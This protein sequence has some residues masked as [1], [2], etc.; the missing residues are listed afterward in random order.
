MTSQLS[1]PDVI[2]SWIRLRKQHPVQALNA[3][4]QLWAAS[5]FTAPLNAPMTPT[6]VLASTQDAL[7]NV[8]CSRTIARQWQWPLVEHPSA[9]HDLP[10]DGARWVIDQVLNWECLLA[11]NQ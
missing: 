7:V 8:E 1:P 5:R 9:G 11:S 6:L 10:L 4:R 2:E 3:L